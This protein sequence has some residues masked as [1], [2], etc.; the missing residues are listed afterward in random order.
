M[1]IIFVYVTNKILTIFCN[2]YVIFATNEQ[3]A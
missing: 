2:N 3:T 1:T